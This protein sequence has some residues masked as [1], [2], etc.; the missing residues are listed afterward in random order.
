MSGGLLDRPMR[1]L[2]STLVGKFGTRVTI[3][4]RQPAGYDEA[5]QTEAVIEN[6]YTGVPALF[7]EFKAYDVDGN[8]VKHGDLKLHLPAAD[9]APEPQKGIHTVEAYGQRYSVERTLG[10]P[11]GNERALWTVQVRR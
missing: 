3:R 7:E 1:G 9:F 2:A 11:S 5:T 10:V 4:E 6:V 8:L